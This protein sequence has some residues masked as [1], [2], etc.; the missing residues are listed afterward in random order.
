[1]EHFS[2]IAAFYKAKGHGESGRINHELYFFASG[3][4]A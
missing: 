2:H 1:M 3:G 4:F